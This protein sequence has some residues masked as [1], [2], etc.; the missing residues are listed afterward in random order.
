MTC[1]LTEFT[2]LL[3]CKFHRWPGC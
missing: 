2:H 3:V 1:S